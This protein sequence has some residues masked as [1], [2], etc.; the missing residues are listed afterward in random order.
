MAIQT[1]FT[2]PRIGFSSF[3][4][5]DTD[6]RNF[7]RIRLELNRQQHNRDNGWTK[8]IKR[9]NRIVAFSNDRDRDAFLDQ[10]PPIIN[11]AGHAVQYN[12]PPR[13]NQYVYDCSIGNDA[14]IHFGNPVTLQPILP[15]GIDAMILHT[16]ARHYIIG[17]DQTIDLT[18][19]DAGEQG[20]IDELNI[21]Y[22]NVI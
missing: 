8:I 9:S 2:Q 20:L 4:M 11:I 22:Q 19:P 14:V 12:Y 7:V 21:Q 10:Q 17:A 15:A 6:T 13:A 3:Y 16:I 5:Y 18:A 1:W